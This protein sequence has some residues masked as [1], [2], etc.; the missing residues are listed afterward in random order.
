MKK[1]SSKLNFGTVLSK[2]EQKNVIGGYTTRQ[3][4][5]CCAGYTQQTDCLSCQN[6]RLACSTCYRWV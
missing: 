5:T 1:F 6:A 4:Y 3:A 2:N